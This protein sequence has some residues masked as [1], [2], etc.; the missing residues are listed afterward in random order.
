MNK[1]NDKQ[2]PPKNLAKDAELVN[3]LNL[4]GHHLLI[5]YGSKYGSTAA[6]A[7]R[8]GSIV[9]EKGAIVDLINMNNQ[10]RTFSINLEKYSGIILGSGIY[11]GNWTP[12]IKKIIKKIKDDLVRIPTAAFAVC[13]E[14]HDP[15]RKEFAHKKYVKDYLKQWNIC[16]DFGSTFAG[17]LDLSTES[18]Y[19]KIELKIVRMINK[20]NSAVKLDS[21]N[22]YRNWSLIEKF[23][24]EFAHLLPYIADS[25]KHSLM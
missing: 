8:I 16:P 22:D 18:P 17:I 11:A 12:K 19:N 20:K 6:I 21:L 13:G 10:K 1:V 23:A 25:K 24:S 3:D 4:K 5:I 9:K 15:S 2:H 14:A 7:A